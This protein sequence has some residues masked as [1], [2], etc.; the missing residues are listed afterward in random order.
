M[1]IGGRIESEV[2]VTQKPETEEIE[3][4]QGCMESEDDLDSY[5]R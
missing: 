4:K 2:A 3:E 5:S 1:E